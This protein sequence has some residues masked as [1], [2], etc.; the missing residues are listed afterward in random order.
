MCLDNLWCLQPNCSHPFA[1]DPFLMSQSTPSYFSGLK[2]YSPT[3]D[4]S[5]R[6][7]LFLVSQVF[8]SLFVTSYIHNFSWQGKYV[9]ACLVHLMSQTRQV[10]GN[11]STQV[12]VISNTMTPEHLFKKKKKLYQNLTLSG[13]YNLIIL[14]GWKIVLS[15]FHLLQF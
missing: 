12:V 15:T 8:Q 10:P 1:I 4:V 9:E 13:W 6:S 5:K 14:I 3:S 7:I 11:P 2:T